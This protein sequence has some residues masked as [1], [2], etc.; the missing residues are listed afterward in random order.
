LLFH[1]PGSEAI[2][3]NKGKVV[4][5]EKKDWISDLEIFDV[6]INA[7]HISE[8]IDHLYGK[9]RVLSRRLKSAA[10]ME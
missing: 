2:Y 3:V 5:R 6:K 1:I 9:E 8:Y 7:A 10:K 4:K